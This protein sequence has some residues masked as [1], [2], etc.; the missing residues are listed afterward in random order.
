MD[1]SA[2][3][4]TQTA[5]GPADGG[6][7]G[8]GMGVWGTGGAQCQRMGVGIGRS[9]DRTRAGGPPHPHLGPALLLPGRIPAF[10]AVTE[11][12]M[13][14]SRRVLNQ[15]RDQH[16]P[17]CPIWPPIRTQTANGPA[18]VEFRAPERAVRAPRTPVKLAT[19]TASQW[20]VKASGAAPTFFGSVMVL[21]WPP[22]V[23]R[24]HATSVRP[25]NSD[26]VPNDPCTTCH[27]VRP[28]PVT[29]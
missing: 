6:S 9:S 14:G 20:A 15:Q 1:S 19:A 25:G 10:V 23:H 16:R 26:L 4:R 22:A 2:E 17:M 12:E 18:T 24:R 27:S 29:Y 21:P 13:T 28:A 8:T 11:R 7:W 5:N 3:I